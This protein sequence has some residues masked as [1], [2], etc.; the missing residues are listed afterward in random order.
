MLR[1]RGR[2]PEAHSPR[3]VAA[4]LADWRAGTPL[5]DLAVR[6][7]PDVRRILARLTTPAE[8]AERNARFPEHR[9]SPR[10]CVR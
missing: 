7:G 4:L 8:R 2:P 1:P 6:H 10:P 3:E 9:N 5:T